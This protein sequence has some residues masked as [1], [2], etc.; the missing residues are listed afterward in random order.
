M[1]ITS[2]LSNFLSNLKNHCLSKK[3]V[4]KQKKTKQII[5]IIDLLVKEGLLNG[6]YLSE[7]NNI[8]ILLKYDKDQKSV[9]NQIELISKPGKRVYVKNKWIFKNQTQSLFIIS[10]QKGFLTHIDAQKF[11]LGGEL[12]CKII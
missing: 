12:I 10:T 9:I 1:I 2:T 7:N 6:Y 3:Q 4:L 5:K 11:N 8:N